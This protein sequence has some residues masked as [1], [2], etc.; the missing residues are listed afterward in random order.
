MKIRQLPAV[1]PEQMI[2]LTRAFYD[3]ADRHM[4]AVAVSPK[5]AEILRDAI[6]PR[7]EQPEG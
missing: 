3:L 7:S 1:T 5:M 6:R 2:E 4:N